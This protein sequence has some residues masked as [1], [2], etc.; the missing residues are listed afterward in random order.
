MARE[1]IRMAEARDLRSRRAPLKDR[2]RSD[3]ERARRLLSSAE[4]CC[5]TLQ[6]MGHGVEVSTTF[7]LG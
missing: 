3:P 6:T 4:R 7:D 2:H 1:N 5:S